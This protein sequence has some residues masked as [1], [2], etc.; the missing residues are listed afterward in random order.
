VAFAG[1][2]KESSRETREGINGADTRT[3]CERRPLEK[4]F[5]KRGASRERCLD[6]SLHIG[7]TSTPMVWSL[8]KT[9]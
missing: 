2:R 4:S 7:G 3:L 9:A 8:L 1:P 5:G 6:F